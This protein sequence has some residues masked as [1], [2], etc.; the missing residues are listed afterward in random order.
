MFTYFIR[1]VHLLYAQLPIL[2]DG[3]ILLGIPIGHVS[4][5]V[6]HLN[7]RLQDFQQNIPELR[8][9]R[10][11]YHAI[12]IIKYCLNMKA[13]HFFRVLPPSLTSTFAQGFDFLIMRTLA[14]LLNFQPQSEDTISEQCPALPQVDSCMLP[15]TGPLRTL[16]AQHQLRQPEAEAGLGITPMVEVAAPAF[17]SA[18]L[19]FFTRA[20]SIFRLTGFFP[21]PQLI[22][23]HELH[24]STQFQ[25][26][27]QMLAQRGA[28][29]VDQDPPE[30]PDKQFW[31]PQPDLLLLRQ[32]V[33]DR[34][35]ATLP[36]AQNQHIL[37]TWFRSTSPAQLIMDALIRRSPSDVARLAHLKSVV[38]KGN[39]PHFTSL[40]PNKVI[41]FTPMAVYTR[42]HSMV[43]T[44]YQLEL[45]LKLSLALPLPQPE[46]ACLCN[47]PFSPDGA[48]S[49]CCK[50]WIG[51]SSIAGH[52]RIVEGIFQEAVI[53]GLNGSASE[54][55]M[56]RSFSHYS[57]GKHA[58][59]MLRCADLMTIR[60]NVQAFG[61]EH[62][63][64][65]FDVKVVSP[66]SQT[67]GWL[68]RPP[69]APNEDQ[70][71]MHRS[72]RE[73]YIKHEAAY[74]P[75]GHAFLAFVLSPFGVLGPSLIRFSAQLAQI[76]LT[77][78]ENY[79][80]LRNLP[81]FSP[82]ELGQLRAKFLSA[83]FSRFTHLALQAAVMRLTGRGV[84][85]IAPQYR[86]INPLH[87]IP[88]DVT[89]ADTLRAAQPRRQPSLAALR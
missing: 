30:R 28:H 48:H 79:R 9:L 1:N 51:Q 87:R 42:F 18:T 44:P 57:S 3:A 16:L 63:S 25:T 6:A 59:G 20:N 53:A 80:Q 77:R 71:F 4:Y 69:S 38:L 7:T 15:Y 24:L 82:A 22:R 14:T 89:Y 70:P 8:S 21:L 2:L 12:R 45:V 33:D 39:D 74:A 36:A 34:M 55:V 46:R 56:R 75:L 86:W 65:V 61:R 32:L 52:N 49:L 67:N 26:V 11:S 29:L 54:H 84:P 35:S 50:Q 81:P 58:D 31:I 73:K 19:K 64:F 40:D 76:K 37:T 60:D 27:S 17:Y 5:I 88:L 43:I 23:A 66:L 47:T 85:P 62:E 68:I 78:C 41:K 10:N 13:V 83:I 72:E